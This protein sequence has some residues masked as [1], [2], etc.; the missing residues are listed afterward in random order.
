MKLCIGA[1]RPYVQI[2]L[3]G[4]CQAFGDVYMLGVTLYDGVLT[5]YIYTV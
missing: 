3:M 2:G 5:C 4:A 1:G